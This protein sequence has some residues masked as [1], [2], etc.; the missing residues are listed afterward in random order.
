MAPNLTEQER[1]L[2]Y[3]KYFDWKHGPE[4]ALA[5]AEFQADRA[6]DPEACMTPMQVND[7]TA[8]GELP[9]EYGC[10]VMPD[11]SGFIANRIRMPS[12]TPEM[13]AWFLTWFAFENARYKI[14]WPESHYGVS[15]S[16]SDQA[17]LL[18]PRRA[19]WGKLRGTTRE[20]LEDMGNGP[21]KIRMTYILPEEF[22][23]D[24][25]KFPQEPQEAFVSI[26]LGGPMDA[27]SQNLLC[28]YFMA[29]PD[30]GGVLRTRFWV[31]WG[32]VNGEKV[33]TL[34]AGA[35]VPKQILR[36]MWWHNIQEFSRL[37]DLLPLLY[38]ELHDKPL[39]YV[40]T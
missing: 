31:G 33:L 6:L 3:A 40:G 4:D 38:E 15:S 9:V 25:S 23:F 18:D 39:D 32:M 12:V 5:V 24:M 21:E 2:P 34:P 28:H 22:G 20:V 19:C 35:H 29:H 27:P 7:L 13:F 14:W 1:K 11:G 16:E 17:K 8:P 10:C 37:R 26:P 36:N 30:G